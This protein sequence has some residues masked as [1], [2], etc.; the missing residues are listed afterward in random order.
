MKTPDDGPAAIHES[1]FVRSFIVRERRE[2][3]LAKLANPKQRAAFLDRLNH[4]FHRD[5][6]E[7]FVRDSPERKIPTGDELCYLVASEREFD[8]RLVPASNVPD[9]L[10]SA[11]FGIIVS[12]IPGKL[13]AYKDEA[14]SE[15]T[16]LE[17]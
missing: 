2:R 5:V 6:D 8:A 15:L 17:R 16:W 12:Y 11:Y 9:I 1:E 7:R 14:W 3:Y 4:Q 10:S 13:A